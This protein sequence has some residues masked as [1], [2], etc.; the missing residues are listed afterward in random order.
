MVR[1]WP[2]VVVARWPVEQKREHFG[3]ASPTKQW[4]D[5]LFGLVMSRR[6][7]VSCGN[8]RIWITIS[9][10]LATTE[11]TQIKSAG[12][13][14]VRVLFTTHGFI[15]KVE[16]IHID[17]IYSVQLPSPNPWISR[18]IVDTV[19]IGWLFTQTSLKLC[20]STSGDLNVKSSQ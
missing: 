4:R 13:D 12:Q 15:H 16:N 11:S 8:E 19:P 1:T 14:Q 10:D 9:T 17:G 6:N 2:T 18:S 5:A 3:V 20:R 7:S